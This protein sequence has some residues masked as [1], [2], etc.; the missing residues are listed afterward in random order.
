MIGISS[1]HLTA[2]ASTKLGIAPGGAHSGYTV[3]SIARGAVLALGIST[4]G[5]LASYLLQLLLAHWLGQELY[6]IYVYAW[7]WAAILAV[8]VTMG[9][10]SVLIRFIPQYETS[11]DL[12]R[13]R[14][15]VHYSSLCTVGFGTIVAGAASC[16]AYWWDRDRTSATAL[17][18]ALW[19]VPPLALITLSSE[20]LR[21]MRRVVA[22]YAP[23][24]LVRPALVAIGAWVATR[25]TGVL[26][27]GAADTI[28]FL[29]LVTISVTQMAF[30]VG[31]LRTVVKGT[32]SVFDPKPWMDVAWPLG[33]AA[34]FTA[35]FEHAPMLLLGML[36]R[37]SD[38]GIYY[39]ASRNA[40][41]V[42]LILTAVNALAAPAFAAVYKR[43]ESEELQS[44]LTELAH[45]TF[46]PSSVAA[47]L[48][49]ILSR[50]LLAMFGPGFISGQPAMLILMLGQIVNVGTGSVGYLLQ[51][52]G[53]QRDYLAVLIACSSINILV[54]LVLI[55]SLGCLG[56]AIAGALTT[57]LWNLSLHRFVNKRLGVHP[58]ILAAIRSFPSWRGS[59]R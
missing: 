47:I 40:G 16:V 30:L 18:L 27:I 26:S 15:I 21:A 45:L 36:G 37:A 12:A 31:I 34:A 11:R 41:F 33:A 38:A 51:M 28:T 48:L 1:R 44:M 49:L 17:P 25:V 7:S 5:I 59:P 57:V 53:F 54:S 42:G 22:A 4:G 10:P 14:G 43:G 24:Q 55:P 50:P 52:T 35:V 6:G 20:G 2:L 32:T 13:L 58:S 29:A 39:V 46:W 3:W 19:A 56:A 9:F 8:I 23:N